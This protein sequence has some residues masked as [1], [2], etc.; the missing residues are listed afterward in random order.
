MKGRKLIGE[1]RGEFYYGEELDNGYSAV[2][3][4]AWLDFAS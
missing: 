4:V 3:K 2:F 1:K